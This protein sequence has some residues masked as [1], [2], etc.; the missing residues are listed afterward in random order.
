[1]NACRDSSG[2]K[3]TKTWDQVKPH[4]YFIHVFNQRDRDAA[5]GTP[6]NEKLT[7]PEPKRQGVELRAPRRP[8]VHGSI[9]EM[10]FPH[11]NGSWECDL[12]ALIVP[13]NQIESRIWKGNEQ[14]LMLWNTDDPNRNYT[15]NPYQLL[16]IDAKTEYLK[17]RFRSSKGYRATYTRLSG[18]SNVTAIQYFPEWKC[19]CEGRLH[20]MAPGCKGTR[21]TD[22][23]GIRGYAAGTKKLLRQVIE[24]ELIGK[25]TT[26]ANKP[27]FITRCVNCGDNTDYNREARFTREPH[28]VWEYP[29][30]KKLW[31]KDPDHD[32]AWE[33]TNLPDWYDADIRVHSQSELGKVDQVKLPNISTLKEEL[34]GR[35]LAQAQTDNPNKQIRKTLQ[36]EVCKEAYSKYKF[37]ETDSSN[38]PVKT[39]IYAYQKVKQYI[40]SQDRYTA[41][42]KNA[43]SQLLDRY[44]LATLEY[45]FVSECRCFA[46]AYPNQDEY[47]EQNCKCAFYNHPDEMKREDRNKLPGPRAAM[48]LS[49]RTKGRRA[50][51]KDVMDTCKKCYGGKKNLQDVCK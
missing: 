14:D 27:W 30:Y 11:E 37:T 12:S 50:T 9:N 16:L 21:P 34:V 49:W 33:V 15:A 7:Y 45:A 6:V 46:A 8:T 23:A 3:V 31:V 39:H 5:S 25:Y 42:Q 20:N 35:K 2:N 48:S 10:V 43:Y 28:Y 19:I 47:K 1:M 18:E 13:F 40:N 41:E 17:M 26:A 22:G 51:F 4:L 29:P 36:D 38:K 24:E 44:S 32:C